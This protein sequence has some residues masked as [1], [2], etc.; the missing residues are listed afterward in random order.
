M[1]RW[2]AFG[3]SSP[4]YH[5]RY[6]AALARRPRDG[7]GH[8]FDG[9]LSSRHRSAIVRAARTDGRTI[10][11]S[12]TVVGTDARPPPR[13]ASRTP[14]QDPVSLSV[15]IVDSAFGVPAADVDVQ[16]RHATGDDWREL[17]RGRT[18]ADGR[19][20]VLGDRDVPPGV[21]QVICDLDAYYAALGALPLNPRAVV[22]F[23]VSESDA[24][25]HLS[26]VVSAHSFMSYRAA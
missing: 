10:G 23:R 15:H 13:G 11:P 12:P 3:P 17:V 5:V 8:G 16:L 7:A 21:Y 9:A 25:M 26:I 14:R 4:G 18:G 2:T 22:E 24:D 19:L 1:V 6:R 20:A